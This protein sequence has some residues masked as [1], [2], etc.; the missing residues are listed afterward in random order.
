MRN[1]DGFLGTGKFSNVSDPYC[2]ISG[3]IGATHNWGETETVRDN[4]NPKWNEKTSTFHLKLL[5]ALPLG[6]HLTKLKCHVWDEDD[7]DRTTAE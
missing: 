4:L 7:K 6:G 1:G 2:R 3:L 5:D